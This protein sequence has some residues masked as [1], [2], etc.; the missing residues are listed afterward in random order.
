MEEWLEE[1]ELSPTTKGNYIRD[2]KSLFTD[3]Q[4]REYSK[5]NPIEHLEKPKA[6]HAEI[7]ILTPA[8]AAKL[9]LAAEETNTDIIPAL[10][11]KLYAGLRTSELL[12]LDWRHLTAEE[13]T[14]GAA[15]AKTRRRRIVAIRPNLQAW[16][17]SRRKATGPIFAGTQNQYHCAVESLAEIADPPLLPNVF[18]HSYGSYLFASLKNENLVAAEMGNSP[19]VFFSNYRALVDKASAEAYWAILPTTQEKII[20]ITQIAANG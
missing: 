19:K 14:I 2:L 8:Q 4:R 20:P 18:R 3:A 9:L 5:R 16:L 1:L 6:I 13:I 15:M 17:G 7:H 12:Q 11:I 10:A